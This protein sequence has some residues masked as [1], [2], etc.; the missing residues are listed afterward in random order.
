MLDRRRETFDQKRQIHPS[1]KTEF[2]LFNPRDSR[3]VRFHQV[4]SLSA[5]NGSAARRGVLSLA[6]GASKPATTH[7]ASVTPQLTMIGT[8]KLSLPEAVVLDLRYST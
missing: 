5:S 8:R 3:V 6:S 4:N 1:R 2:R 7:A